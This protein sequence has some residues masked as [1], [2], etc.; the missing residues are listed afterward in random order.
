MTK[1]TK[2]KISL[3]EYLHFGI[4]FDYS[5]K[6]IYHDKFIDNLIELVESKHLW[7]GGTTIYNLNRSINKE[8]IKVIKNFIYSYPNIHDVSFNIINLNKS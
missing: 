8:E 5:I 3:K 1:R 6:E 7:L 4:L 2:K